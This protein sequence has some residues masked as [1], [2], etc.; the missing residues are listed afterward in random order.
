MVVQYNVGA[1]RAVLGRILLH[2][3]LAYWADLLIELALGSK[4]CHFWLVVWNIFYV[5]IYWEE[6]SQL[7][8]IFQSGRY[9]TNQ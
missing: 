7:T 6:S 4:G 5:S 8:N 3:Q 2:L 9:T 1:I